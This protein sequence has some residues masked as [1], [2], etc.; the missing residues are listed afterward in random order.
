MYTSVY[1]FNIDMHMRAG[2]SRLTEEAPRAKATALTSFSS[3]MC[4]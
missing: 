4:V 3:G 1:T 2:A